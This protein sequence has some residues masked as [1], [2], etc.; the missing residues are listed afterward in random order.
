MVAAALFFSLSFLIEA[1]AIL[2]FLSL[3][4]GSSLLLVSSLSFGALLVFLL[5]T[6]LPLPLLFSALLV[7]TL[8]VSLALLLLRLAFVVTTLLFSLPALL[9]VVVAC[10]L[11]RRLL[12]IV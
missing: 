11:V 1:A 3:E 4:L 8:A 10:L 7:L 5:L 9:I 12:L 2:F 6:L